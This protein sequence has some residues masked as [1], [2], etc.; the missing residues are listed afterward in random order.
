M[1][2]YVKCKSKNEQN[3]WNL[4]NM[5]RK[6]YGKASKRINFE[7][8]KHNEKKTDFELEKNYQVSFWGLL[9][10]IT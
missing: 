8:L 2:M 10:S 3:R 5:W 7:T 1:H 4:L 9:P 6:K